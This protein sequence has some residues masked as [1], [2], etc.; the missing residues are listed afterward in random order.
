MKSGSF[1]IFVCLF[2]VRDRRW[3]NACSKKS[4]DPALSI[5]ARFQMLEM[6]LKI[7]LFPKSYVG[8]GTTFRGASLNNIGIYKPITTT[9]R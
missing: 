2:L 7:E 1:S 9:I 3:S 8:D 5:E 6:A 4:V